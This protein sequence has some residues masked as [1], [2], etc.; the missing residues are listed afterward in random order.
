VRCLAVVSLLATGCLHFAEEPP[1]DPR[2][3][4]NWHTDLETDGGCS[5][6]DGYTALLFAEFGGSGIYGFG[7]LVTP[8]HGTDGETCGPS[9]I[10]QLSLELYRPGDVMGTTPIEGA[11]PVATGETAKSGVYKIKIEAGEYTLLCTDPYDGRIVTGDAE[12]KADAVALYAIDLDH[13]G[14]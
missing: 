7:R 8:C 10:P 2:C 4:K 1:Q 9:M 3:P 13:S 5:P 6:P 11:V 12:V 14:N